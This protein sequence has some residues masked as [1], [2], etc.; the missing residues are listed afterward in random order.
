MRLDKFLKLTKLIKRRTVAKD[1]SVAGKVI[2]DRRTVKP[3]YTVK[4]GD[5]LELYLGDYII[6]VKVLNVDEKSVRANPT[7][8]YELLG[9]SLNAN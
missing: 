8:A 9:K 2:V 6:F 5:Q 1:I 7:E 4:V 3:S